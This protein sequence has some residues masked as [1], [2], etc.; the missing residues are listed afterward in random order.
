MPVASRP[1]RDTDDRRGTGALG[2]VLERLA[3]ADAVGPLALAGAARRAPGDRGV[4]RRTPAAL[5]R[6]TP[7]GQPDMRTVSE[8]QAEPGMIE[9]DFWL[10]KYIF[11]YV[12][13]SASSSR[14]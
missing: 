5:R 10:T 6:G 11:F 4:A 12:R 3:N 2:S 13:T 14:L 7:T 1:F 9:Q 8:C